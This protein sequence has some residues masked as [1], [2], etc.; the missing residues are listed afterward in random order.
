ME[1]VLTM[2]NFIPRP[3]YMYRPYWANVAWMGAV[4]CAGCCEWGSTTM[5][6]RIPKWGITC[7]RSPHCERLASKPSMSGVQGSASVV[8]SRS[9]DPGRGPGGEPP[10]THGF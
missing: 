5:I 4:A 2:A 9:K 10:E 3:L 1:H 8:G 6:P 7:G